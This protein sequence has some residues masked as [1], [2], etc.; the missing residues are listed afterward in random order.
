LSYRELRGLLER[1]GF[2]SFVATDP[3]GAPLTVGSRRLRLVARK[4]G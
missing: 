4:P 2:T 1:A 3:D